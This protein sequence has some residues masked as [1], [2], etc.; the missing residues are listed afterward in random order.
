VQSLYNKRG[1]KNGWGQYYNNSQL[2]VNDAVKSIDENLYNAFD[3]EL[4]NSDEKGV[5]HT[6]ITNAFIAVS[7]DVRQETITPIQAAKLLSEAYEKRGVNGLEGIY[8]GATGNLYPQALARAKQY[9]TS[10]GEVTEGKASREISAE[11]NINSNL[12]KGEFV[13]EQEIQDSGI[14]VHGRETSAVGR[15]ENNQRKQGNDTSDSSRLVA[16]D[17]TVRKGSVR[18]SGRQRK[19]ATWMSGR[20][21]VSQASWLRF[22]ET[23]LRN[24]AGLSLT[25]VEGRTVPSNILQKFAK[26][27]F[28]DESGKLLVLY[29]WTPNKFLVFAR[30][31]IGFH[32]GGTYVAAYDRRE[33]KTVPQRGADIVKEVYLNIESPLVLQD[34]GGFWD[35]YE[36]TGKLVDKGVI[37]SEERTKISRMEGYV[38][39]DHDSQANKYLRKLLNKL[40]YDGIIYENAVEGKGTLSAIAFSPDQIYTVS[41]ETVGSNEGKASRELDL[42]YMSAVERGDMATAQRMVDEAAKKAG[43]TVKAYHGTNVKFNEFESGKKNGWL[44]KGIYFSDNKSYAKQNGKRVISAFIDA[45]KIY[46]SDQK[47]HY[48]VLAELQEK[49]PNIN[50]LNIS[51]VLMENG[52]DAISYTDWDKGKIISIFSPNRI[53]SADPVTYDDDGNVIPLSERFNPGNSDIR[54]SRELD[55]IDFINEQAGEE[56]DPNLTKTQEVAK[57]RGELEKMNVGKGEVMAVMKLADKMFDLYGGD[58]SISDFRY[59]MF[60]A[61]KLALNGSE[62]GFEA[63]YDIIHTLSREVAYNPKDLGGEAELLAEIKREIRGTKMFVHEA[64]KTSGEFDGYGGYGT[65]RKS[66]LGKFMLANDGVAADVKYGELQNLYGESFFPDVNTVS[67]QLLQMAKLMDTPLSEYMMVTDKELESTADEMVQSLLSK[68]GDIWSR[69]IKSGETIV[70]PVESDKFSNRS[71]FAN[72]LEGVAQNDIERNKL[73]QYKEKNLFVEVFAKLFS[74]S[75][76]LSVK[77]LF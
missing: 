69:A 24:R 36:I 6:P 71:L 16:L 40:G 10:A 19:T 49:F 29:H 46:N 60:E 76:H 18:E 32:F 9:S 28:T 68:L 77:K 22:K 30:G 63:A 13:N 21:F 50:E 20:R 1:G 33:S 5:T 59:G 55:F 44:G 41:E 65:F 64:D 72:A 27:I 62:T 35:A 26:T 2:A 51:Q 66:H 37:S 31:D 54:Y 75:D 25:D 73:Q 67:E 61:T 42:D 8:N 48:A 43:Y 45:G 56:S 11:N 39:G 74:K 34:Y 7:E 58:S 15:S 70:A 4:N 14:L 57:V 12:T 23:L 3:E 38:E 53:K 47:D 17:G 52:Y